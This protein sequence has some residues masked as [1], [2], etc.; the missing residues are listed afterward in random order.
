MRLNSTSVKSESMPDVIFPFATPP[1][2]RF[3][4]QNQT[5]FNWNR[6]NPDGSK[7]KHAGVD[8]EANERTAVLAMADGK[9][10]RCSPFYEGTWAIEIQH[11][12]L[13]I[14]RYGEVASHVLVNPGV[15][16]KKGT[17]IGFVGKRKGATRCMLHLELYSD[18]RTTDTD[19]ASDG[20]HPLSNHSTP[21]Q[22]RSDL[23]DPT[24]MAWSALY[25]AWSTGMAAPPAES[26]QHLAQILR[27]AQP[28]SSSP[29]AGSK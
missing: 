22:R 28:L 9:V 12:G 24:A 27:Q 13:G 6:T 5:S 26:N 19:A 2:N 10:L 16:V 14:L 29:I 4:E 20:T 8:L 21:Y 7:R 1:K 25:P 17:I 15:N 18:W 11:P 23:K 3:W